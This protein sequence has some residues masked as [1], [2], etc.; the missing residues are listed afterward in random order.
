MVAQTQEEAN[1]IMTRFESR[2]D[3][4]IIAELLDKVT[5]EQVNEFYSW[6]ND[7]QIAEK[8]RGLEE[9]GQER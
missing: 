4:L 7:C 1:V 8:M 9:D 2:L 3:D 6:G 5:P